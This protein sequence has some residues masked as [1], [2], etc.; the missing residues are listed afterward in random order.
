M[1]FHYGVQSFDFHTYF[2][3]ASEA[4]VAAATKLKTEVEAEFKE[5]LADGRVRLFKTHN[6]SIGP[7]PEAHGMFEADTRDPAAFLKLLNFYQL[8][9]GPLSVLIHPRTD[10]SELEDHTVHALW[11]GDQKLL[12]VEFLE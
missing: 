9:H 12:K 8:H 4:E 5:E 6:A 1:A 7:H 11:L 3:L 10:K 2:T